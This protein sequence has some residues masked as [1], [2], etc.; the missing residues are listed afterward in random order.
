MGKRKNDD[1]EQEDPLSEGD[2]LAGEFEDLPDEIELKSPYTGDSY[3][4]P[5]DVGGGQDRAAS[6]EQPEDPYAHLEQDPNVIAKGQSYNIGQIHTEVDDAEFTAAAALSSIGND[7]FQVT[8]ADAKSTTDN[9]NADDE[10]LADKEDADVEL[11][12]DDGQPHDSPPIKSP[13]RFGETPEVIDGKIVSTKRKFG[14]R[15]R[16]PLKKDRSEKK[17]VCLGENILEAE[18][19]F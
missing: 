16:S 1:P 14:R 8:E 13:G 3:L 12:R 19:L 4:L 7:P 2:D 11:Y 5:L 9:W 15:R 18:D 17:R 6:S 10:A